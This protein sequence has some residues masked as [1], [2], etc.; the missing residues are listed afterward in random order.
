MEQG[1]NTGNYRLKPNNFDTVRKL[2]IN[3]PS[4][5]QINRFDIRYGI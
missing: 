2:N 4:V 5:R 1:Y 3:V